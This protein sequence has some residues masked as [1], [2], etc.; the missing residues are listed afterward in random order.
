MFSDV[1]YVSGPIGNP[2]DGPFDI[3]PPKKPQQPEKP[4][5][6]NS[7]SNN[8]FPYPSYPFNPD[9][10]SIFQ[11]TFGDIFGS[12]PGAGA[13]FGAGLGAGLGAGGGFNNWFPGFPSFESLPK[14]W[15]KG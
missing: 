12:Q 4:I 8:G 13:G 14:P 9:T 3:Q 6:T 2:D 1:D 11:H 15:W 5:N 10:S 7:P